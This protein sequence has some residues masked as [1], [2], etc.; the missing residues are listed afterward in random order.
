MGGWPGFTSDRQ[1]DARQAKRGFAKRLPPDCAI[2]LYIVLE[3]QS[4][5]TGYIVIKKDPVLTGLDIVDAQPG[6]DSLTNQPILRFRFS[7]HG[8]R[9]FGAFTKENINKPFA[10]ILDGKLLSAPII[11][12][13]ILGGGGADQLV[14]FS[15][16]GSGRSGPSIAHLSAGGRVH[17]FE[18]EYCASLG[19]GA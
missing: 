5:F 7:E 13:P 3:D 6:F 12:E 15:A 18:C 10:I 1:K 8:G 17:Y 11:R 16:Q 4:A 2:G 9:V 19:S 14:T